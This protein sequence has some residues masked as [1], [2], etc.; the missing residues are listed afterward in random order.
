MLAKL[1]TGL[2]NTFLHDVAIG[3]DGAAHFT[4][5]NAPQVFRVAKD[6]TGWLV[7]A[8]VDATGTIA[9]QTGFNLGGIVATPDGRALVVARAMSGACGASTCERSWSPPSA[10]VPSF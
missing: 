9:A 6:R 10:S 7:S 2:D 1:D 4:N 8:V 3:R 5:S